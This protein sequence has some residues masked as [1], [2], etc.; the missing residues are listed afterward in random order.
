M[1][2]IISNKKYYSTAWA[3]VAYYVVGFFSAA[4]TLQDNNTPIPNKSI[5]VI[6]VYCFVCLNMF[7][8]I[9]I[10]LVKSNHWGVSD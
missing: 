9:S 1:L 2:A 5:L 4:N 10:R 3:G 7:M 8:I 6:D